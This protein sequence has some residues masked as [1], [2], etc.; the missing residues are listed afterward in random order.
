[1][2]KRINWKAIFKGFAWLSCLAGMVVLMSFIDAKKQSVKCAKIEILIPG[3][4]NFIEIEEIDAIL[5]QNEG[6]LIGR[7]LEGINLHKIE[8]SIAANP[9]IGFVKVYADMNGT[10]FVEV[11][12]R[13]P[14]LRILNAGGQDYYVD[15]DGLKMP[16]SPN[17]TA[18]VLVA[19]GNILEGF[20][21]RVDTLMTSAAKD[22][23]KTAVFVKR[24]TLWDAQIEQLHVNDKLDIE[25]VPRVGNQRII[26]GN[27]KD[28]ETKMSNLLAFYKQAMPKVGWNAYRSINL[29]Y[30]N[31][32]VCEKRDSLTIKKLEKPSVPDSIVQQQQVI[33]A[34]VQ[35]AIQDE[36]R[37]ATQAA[38]TETK[39]EEKT[40][41]ASAKTENKKTEN[42]TDKNK[43]SKSTEN[44]ESVKKEKETKTEQKQA[45]TKEKTATKDKTVKTNR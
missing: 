29:K 7:N 19:T 8:K 44:K 35:S 10:V 42:T 6:D 4:D 25:M 41:S 15:S 27:A 2:L 5:K 24:D 38:A 13:Q 34:Q 30:I 21:G 16:I 20:N 37:K 9:Y 31:Q 33:N 18:N 1:M 32:I 36:I 39:K 40:A 12:Q 28:I 17:F 26:L 45:A 14:V 22:L 23:Y 3:A 43:A 11:K